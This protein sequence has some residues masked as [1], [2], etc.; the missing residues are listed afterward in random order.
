MIFSHF[1]A[2]RL[3]FSTYKFTNATKIK[4]YDVFVVFNFFLASTN[5]YI[6]SEKLRI[7]V[8]T[9]KTFTQA[10]PMKLGKSNFNELK[11]E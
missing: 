6:L 2:K 10:K 9:T 8:L 1:D 7:E 4:F 3:D 5:F 11:A